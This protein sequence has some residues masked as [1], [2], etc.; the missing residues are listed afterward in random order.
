M[1]VRC[2]AVVEECSSADR[3]VFDPSIDPP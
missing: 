1:L 3:H 2:P